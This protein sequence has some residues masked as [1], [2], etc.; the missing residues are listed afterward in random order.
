MSTIALT[1]KKKKN[2]NTK[3]KEKPL[4]VTLKTLLKKSGPQ[5]LQ[6]RE[7]LGPQGSRAEP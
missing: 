3:Q 6:I 1:N 2:V 7:M 4:Q 5:T